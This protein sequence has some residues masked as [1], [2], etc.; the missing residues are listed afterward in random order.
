MVF[1]FSLALPACFVTSFAILD[2][3]PVLLSAI[4]RALSTTVLFLLN[5]RV[6]K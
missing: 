3:P 4:V 5:E 2:A 6:E 1:T